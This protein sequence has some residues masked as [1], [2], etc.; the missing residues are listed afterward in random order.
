MKKIILLLIVLG[1]A[2]LILSGCGHWDC[3]NG[4]NHGQNQVHS[5][6]SGCGHPGD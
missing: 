6:Y 3:G 2:T 5:H 1:A 4:H